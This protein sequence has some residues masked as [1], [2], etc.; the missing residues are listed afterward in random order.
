MKRILLTII[1]S[2]VALGVVFASGGSEEGSAASSGRWQDDYPTLVISAVSS[3][4][5]ADRLARY[6]HLQDYLSEA[7]GVEVEFF[8][9]SDYAGTIE[10]MAAGKVHIGRFGTASYARAWRVTEGGVRAVLCDLNPD[11]SSGYHSV[12][13]VREDSPYQSIEDLEG[14]SLAFADPNSTSGFLVP[15]Y[16]LT[17]AEN[18]PPTEYFGETGFAGN[19]EGA[20][21]ALLD[22]TFDAAANWYTND[23]RSNVQRMAAKGMI[24]DGLLRVIWKSPL[25]TNGPYAVL[26]DLPQSLV[27]DF[28]AAMLNWETNDPEGYVG[29]FAPNSPTNVMEVNH[30]RYADFISMQEWVDSNAQ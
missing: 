14:Q 13:W 19:H 24:E 6:S 18:K 26:E 20:I 7:L 1:L 12:I 25:I 21:L 5:E 29:F 15:T 30:E 17:T 22:G 16:Y 3:E 9:A 23:E 8:S 2:I 4:N 11:G 28:V 27:D 10:A